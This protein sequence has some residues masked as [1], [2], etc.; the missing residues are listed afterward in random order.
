MIVKI[1][2]THTYLDDL[3]ITLR[4]TD[5]TG[6]YYLI[7]AN[8]GTSDNLGTSSAVPTEF[9]DGGSAVSTLVGPATSTTF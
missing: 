2:L 5:Q 9:K 4:N 3:V 6:T 8:G 7:Q 1:Y